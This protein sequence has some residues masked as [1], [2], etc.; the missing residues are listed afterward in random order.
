MRIALVSPYS[1]TY[2]GGVTR[3]IEALAEE[4][5][6]AGHEVKVLAPFDPPDRAASVSHR[7]AKPQQLE[8]PPYLISLG[9][10]VGINANGAQ[11]NLSISPLG[12]ARLVKALREGDFDVVHIHEPVA[13]LIGWV[14]ASVPGV[15]LVGT[16]HSYST[17]AVP[18]HIATAFGARA[19]MNHLHKRIAVSEAAA[20]TGK[21]WFGGRYDVI[22]NGV[23]VDAEALAARVGGPDVF[24]SEL[25][26]GEIVLEAATPLKLLF[27]GQ[28][29]TRKG[30]PLLL[31]AFEALREQVPAEL[32][33]IGPSQA[34]I[35]PLMLDP[36]G[37]RVLGKVSDAVKQAELTAA[38][39]LVAPSLGG[40]SFG[41]VLTEA[42][43]AGTTVVASDIAGYRDVVTH[44]VDGILVP[45]GDAQALAEALRE[46]FYDSVRRRELARAAADTVAAQVL[47]VY[48]EAIA[49]PAA[50]SAFES[51][52]VMVGAIPADLQPPVRARRLPTLEVT[53]VGLK[54]K[55]RWVS[56]ARRGGALA[57]TLGVIYVAY[58]ALQTIGIGKIGTTLI[59]S[60][61]SYV[62]AGLVVMCLA[63]AMRAVSWHAIL[64]AAL[65]RSGVKLGDAMQGTMIGVLM[66]STLPARLGEPARALVVA[67]RT[68]KPRE[69]LPVV[70]GTVVSQTIL[71]IVA[72]IILGVITFSS[73]NFFAGHENVLEA[74]AI[75]PA[76]LLAFVVLAPIFLRYGPGGSRFQR[77]RS[78]M[79]SAQHALVR[80][81]AGLVV[82]RDP[83]LAAQAT[84]FQL[85]AWALQAC[86]CY[87]LLCALG[88]SGRTGFVGAAAILFAVNVTA[89]VPATPANLG[90]FQ[91]ACAVVLHTGW[92]IHTGTGIAYGVIL[93]A[94]EVA[95]A[96][97][98]GMP[99]LL[100]EGMS[101]K[102]VRLR[103]MNAT[104]VKLPPRPQMPWPVA[105]A[106]RLRIAL[107][108]EPP[109]VP[110][111]KVRVAP[112]P[113]VRG[114]PPPP[115]EVAAAAAGAGTPAA[116][117]HST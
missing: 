97:L 80:V 14:A 114:V 26:D 25:P 77:A 8:A 109:V 15:R 61:P 19:M 9:R 33:V 37:I 13:P 24:G 72:L 57:L 115:A 93:Q 99:S 63:M 82:F 58:K 98:L 68:G 51:F 100:K 53:P 46:L 44:E 47:G 55:R 102:E 69:D 62:V 50:D 40:E 83:K 28:A 112:P 52:A 85:L 34:E 67:R 91:G 64:K 73:V 41:M 76:V 104:P 106:P 35:S 16:Y 94:V 81:R 75:A 92:H 101:W 39:V 60:T 2:P 87:L 74:V 86:S 42:M 88:L 116:P 36:T 71:N 1:W 17:K 105:G 29:V 108:P 10:T 111:P 66:S 48:A 49:M 107:V 84:F 5:I 95:T 22:P 79:E 103:A 43:A 113:K 110:A 7:G 56:R 96:I 90:V 3:H 30:L 6:A 89:V 12:Q 23:H 117:S 4:F 45:V 31:R 38:D 18:N 78:A 27:V 32:T 21:R 54:P 11:S 70:L 65:P 20:W 59:N